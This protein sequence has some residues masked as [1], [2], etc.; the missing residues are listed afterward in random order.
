MALPTLRVR[1][2]RSRGTLALLLGTHAG[3]ALPLLSLASHPIVRV[4]AVAL[5]LLS[6][7]H[8]LRRAG[9]LA[10]NGH[11][12]LIELAD[13]D[14][15]FL[16]ESGKRD[17]PYSIHASTLVHPMLVVLV[18][19]VP[20]SGPRRRLAIVPDALDAVQF[21]RL[22]ARLRWPRSRRWSDR[23]NPGKQAA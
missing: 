2:D 11:G 23:T 6:L 13:D 10:P 16:E 21:R 3:F 20:D 5:V 9:W 1:I 4:G 15:V 22:R 18:L 17:G 8:A 7:V 12:Q 19:Y 14:T